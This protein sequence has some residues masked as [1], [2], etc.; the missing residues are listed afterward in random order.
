[1]G[2]SMSDWSELYELLGRLNPVIFPLKFK[3]YNFT[4]YLQSEPNTFPPLGGSN[5]QNN[6]LTS[7]G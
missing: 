6:L 2:D 5:L 7:F 3:A 1:M 4:N